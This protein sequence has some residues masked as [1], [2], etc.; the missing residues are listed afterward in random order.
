MNVTAQRIEELEI[1]FA[2]QEST[3]DDLNAV[4][5]RQQQQIDRLEILCKELLDRLRVT[6]DGGPASAANENEKPPHY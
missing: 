6:T 3:L 1:K 4:V 2:Y 5:S